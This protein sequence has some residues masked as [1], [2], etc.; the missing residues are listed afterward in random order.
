MICY[1]YCV[2]TLKVKYSIINIAGK[3]IDHKILKYIEGVY[4]M[5]I[6]KIFAGVFASALMACSLSAFTASADDYPIKLMKGDINGDGRIDVSDQNLLSLHVKGISALSASELES[7]DVNWDHKVNVT[8]IAL[9]SAHIAKKTKIHTGDVDGDE[10]V[11]MDDVYAVSEHV[12]GHVMLSEDGRV[13][14][15]VNGDG[16]INISDVTIIC[17]YLKK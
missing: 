5:N 4:T 10:V 1:P 13:A 9:I 17:A 11:T 3:M 12:K 8:D 2:L 6:K 14:A 7:A 15:D 16:K